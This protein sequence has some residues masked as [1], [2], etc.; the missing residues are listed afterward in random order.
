MKRE[1][2][3]LEALRAFALPILDDLQALPREAPWGAWLEGLAAL[4]ARTLRHP[5][6]V[7]AGRA[8]PRAWRPPER[9]LGGLA[10]LMPMA[11]VGPVGLREVRVVLARRLANLTVTP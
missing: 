10:E 6:R 11:P 8:A 5:E 2:A 1:M 7:V 9:V 3:Q 4:A